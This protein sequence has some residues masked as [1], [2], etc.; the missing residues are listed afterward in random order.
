MPPTLKNDLL[1]LENVAIPTTAVRPGDQFIVRARVHNHAAN[2]LNLDTAEACN[3][4]T[5]PCQSVGLGNGFC[6]KVDFSTPWDTYTVGPSCVEVVHGDNVKVFEQAMTAPNEP[7]DYDI[8]ARM[9]LSPTDKSSDWAT[10]T[11]TVSPDAPDQ[12][13]TPDGGDGGN[14]DDGPLQGITDLSRSL[15]LLGGVY[16]AAR[17][18]GDIAPDE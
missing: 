8:S 7:G 6:T 15:A 10:K 13:D 4:S 5:T 14:G 18:Y 2:I 17:V 1:V 16:V 12:P 9:R 11:V 3:L